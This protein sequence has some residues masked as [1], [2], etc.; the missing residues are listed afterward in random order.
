MM[1]FRSSAIA[2]SLLAQCPFVVASPALAESQ[3]DFPKPTIEPATTQSPSTQ[4]TSAESAPPELTEIIVTANKRAESILNVAGAI[5]AF[6]GDDLLNKGITS[7]ADFAGQT[8]GLQ[9]NGGYGTGAPV[10]RG[11]NT[12]ADFGQSVGITVDGAP[13]GPSSSFQPGGASSLDLD[14]IDL[15]RVEVLKGPQGTVYGANTLAGLISYTLREPDL[16]KPTAIVR[17]NLSGTEYGGTSY[18]ERAAISVPL[19]E[20]RLAV[21][22]SNFYDQRAGFIDNHLAGVA[23]QNH[24]RSY[25]VQGS[26]VFKPTDQL[27]IFVD[28]FYQEKNQ[29]A[30]DQV[31][32]TANRT[33]RD[34]DLVYNDYLAP[35]TNRR[36]QFVLA[37]IDYDVDF[38]NLTSV[39]SYQ[40]LNVD[41]GIPQETGTL[42][43]IFVNVL[44]LLDGVAIPAPGLLSDDTLND[45]K[46]ITQEVRLTSTGSGPISWLAGSYYTHE[47]SR[48]QQ[49]VNARMTSG[50]LASLINPTLLVTVPTTLTEYSGFGNITYALSSVFDLTGGLRIGRIDQVNRTLLSGTDAA[51]Y[52]LFFVL[53]GLGAGPPADT[54]AQHGSKTVETY[55]ATARYHF[56]QDGMIFARFATGFRPGG[57]NFPVPGLAPVYNPDQTYNYELGL[58]RRFWEGRGSIDLTGY[59]LDWK[60][61]LA[62]TSAGG[63]NGFENAGDARVYGV[64]ANLTVRPVERL[65]LSGSFAYSD[66]RITRIAAGS[67]VAKVGD[68]LPNNPRLSGSLSMEYRVPV[69]ARWEAVAGGSARF[70]G[71][72][73]SSPQSSIT[74]PN[75]VLPGYSLFDA[76]VGLGSEHLDIDLFIKNLADKRAQLAAFTQLGINQITV[77]QPRTIGAAVT[78][79]Y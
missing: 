75:Y 29:Y 73:N 17:G 65:S 53:N 49:S 16:Q 40:H 62:F 52:R 3:A 21:G 8:P 43:T 66:S 10:I 55:L 51:A 68:T 42:N 74:F 4:P 54:G 56:S 38:A 46:K 14:P 77:Q 20:D 23:D 61:F 76:H 70:V 26:V 9:F 50:A 11:I 32:Y 44:P 47:R 36:T 30:Q 5:N 12:G 13:V 71:S 35:N 78:F 22:V 48:Q 37:K 31:I 7:I 6:R 67:I 58:K 24:W 34:G 72:R 2:A 25:G 79:K 19:I 15:E 33:P 18:A 28:G 1:K 63:L 69:N 64:E 39:T 45:F 41:Y 27:H 57:P 60:D 59:Y